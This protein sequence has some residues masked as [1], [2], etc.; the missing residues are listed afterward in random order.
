MQPSGIE[1]NLVLHEEAD[2]GGR[3]LLR[4]E[5]ESANANIAS[6]RDTQLCA[7]DHIVALAEGPIVLKVY[8]EVVTLLFEL[9]RDLAIRGVV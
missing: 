3:P 7:A 6:G 9:R 8:V 4:I 5:K 1:R 2:Q